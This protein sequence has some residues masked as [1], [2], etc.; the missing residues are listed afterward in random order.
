VPAWRHGLVVIAV[1]VCN[2][3]VLPVPPRP[4]PPGEFVTAR[5][6]TLF[7]QGEPFR[8]VG[9]N[10]Y[11]L[12]EHA[13]RADALFEVLAGHGVKVVRFWA[14]QRHC[15]PDGLDFSRFDAITAAARRHDVLLLPVLENHWGAC[16]YGPPIKPPTWYENGWRNDRL[17]PLPWLEYARAVVGRYREEPQILAWQLINE[18]EIWPDTTGNFGILQ[19]FAHEAA[20][21]LKAADPNHLISLGLLGLG[22]PSTAHAR[23]RALHDCRDLDLVTAHD[24]GYIAEA[25]PGRREV[26]PTNSFFADLLA[27]RALRKPFLATESCVP[28]PWVDGDRQRRVELFRAKIEA[29]FAAGGAGYLLW[30]FEPV[31][32]SECGFD[33]YDPLLRLL[34]EVSLRLPEAP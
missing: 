32:E 19:K 18:P 2:L 11:R 27:A 24:H 8:F 3:S 12:A 22:Q 10:C 33:A 21:E 26:R 28:L 17:G 7:R 30:N 16:T 15:G 4:Q 34:G 31:I 6:P 9:V 25:M 13:A 29:F 23:Y 20:R 14:F 5:G 1:G